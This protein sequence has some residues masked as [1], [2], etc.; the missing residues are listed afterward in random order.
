MRSE[1]TGEGGKGKG[2]Q[3]DD[4]DRRPAQ[5]RGSVDSR[6]IGQAIARHWAGRPAYKLPQWHG[7]IG[8]TIMMMY[9][10]GK[11]ADFPWYQ[12]SR[13]GS[14]GP[15]TRPDT[16]PGTGTYQVASNNKPHWRPA[17]ANGL[18]VAQGTSHRD[19]RDTTL[20]LPPL[21]PR[22]RGE[23]MVWVYIQVRTRYYT[24]M[25]D[26]RGTTAKRPPL[27]CAR[28]ERHIAAVQGSASMTPL[29]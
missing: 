19:K 3:G 24:Y 2:P 15:G 11:S 25:C 29:P 5:L 10:Q 23:E 6:K 26:G 14:A 12:V 27:S 4:N 18:A 13:I 21:L 16:V 7:Q 17:P 1:G 22:I 8:S 9:Q 20:L 28:V